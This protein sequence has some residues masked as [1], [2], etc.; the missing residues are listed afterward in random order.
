MSDSSEQDAFDAAW[1]EAQGNPAEPDTS[2]PLEETETDPEAAESTETSLEPGATEPLTDPAPV[3]DDIWSNA[4]PEQRAAFEAAQAESQRLKHR[5]TSDDGRVARYQRD[6]DATLSAIG[7]VA[8]VTEKENI[9]DYLQSEEWQKVKTDYGDDLKPIFHLVET[10]ANHN[11]SMTERFSA[12]DEA[13]AEAFDLRQQDLLTERAPDWRELLGKDQFG[14]WLN[15]Q[16]LHVQEAFGRNFE[17][18]TD[19]DQAADVVDR[20]RAFLGASHPQQTPQQPQLDHKRAV[21]LD[22]SKSARSRPPVVADAADDFEALA[23][24]AMAI[25]DRQV[26]GVR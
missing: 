15:S 10:L 24:Q 9:A 6:R 16:P 25:K 19:I 4:T 22:A 2:A 26:A 14:P 3:T 12:M 1:Q 20:F 7:K 23:K 17:R 8:S 5:L 18:L 13:D 21:Q 11:Q